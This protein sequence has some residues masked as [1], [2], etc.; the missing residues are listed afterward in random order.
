[1]KKRIGVKI[2]T[3]TIALS[4][5]LP[6]V[7]AGCSIDSEE[8]TESV[9]DSTVETSSADEVVSSD[10]IDETVIDRDAW[11]MILVNY[12]HELDPDYEVE[13]KEIPGGQY[14]DA[15]IYDD[16]IQMLDDCAATG[17]NPGVSSGYR[18]ISLQ[19]LFYDQEVQEWMSNG[20]SEEDAKIMAKT[21]VAKP[22]TSEHHTGLAVDII[23]DGNMSLVEDFKDTDV[24]KW[25][26]ENSYKYGFILR[27]PENKK[28]ITGV[29][30][31]PWHFRYVGKET[32]E[33]LYD[34]GLCLEEYLGVIDT[35]DYLVYEE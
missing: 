25:M 21:E 20:Y 19:Q 5:M 11:N 24:G 27:Y 1:M 35:P 10:V 29:I 26:A 32:A 8:S 22:G 3:A 15:R 14:V 12:A 34:S 28:H 4:V 23:A 9:V 13:L 31:E 6:A 16:L 18:D 17:T 33:I 30:Y 2:A 7:L